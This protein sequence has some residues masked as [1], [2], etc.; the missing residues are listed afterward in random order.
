MR[1]CITLVTQQGAAAAKLGKRTL[2]RVHEKPNKKAQLGTA[3]I[4]GEQAFR[5]C[6]TF[7]HRFDSDR[8]LQQ[9]PLLPAL[10]LGQGTTEAYHFQKQPFFD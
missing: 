9:A 7:I 6:K 1:S 2:T 3:V 10:T 8:R 4:S 5:D